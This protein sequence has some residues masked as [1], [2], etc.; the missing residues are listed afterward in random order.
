MENSGEY[1]NRMVGGFIVICIAMIAISGAFIAQNY[2]NLTLLGAVFIGIMLFL[3][4][5]LLHGQRLVRREI[6]DLKYHLGGPSDIEDGLLRRIDDLSRQIA[7]SDI[8]KLE[9]SIKSISKDC[10]ANNSSIQQIAEELLTVS[11]RLEDV[12]S[13][14]HALEAQNDP[15]QENKIIP[16]RKPRP[17]VAMAKST[18]DQPLI[19]RPM[20][21]GDIGVEASEVPQIG[22]TDL[23]EHARSRTLI[24]RLHNAVEN[25][26]LELHLQPIVKL[27]DREP[28]FYEST[29]RMKDDDGDYVKQQ[30]LL[31]F[32]NSEQLAVAFDSQLLH[33]AIRVLR[34]LNELQKR[35]GLFCPVSIATL[36]NALA[37]EEVHTLLR[38]NVALAGSLVLEIDQSVLDELD[39]EG[40]NRLSQLVELGYSLLLNNVNR[41]DLDGSLMHSAGFRNLKVSVNALL[42]ISDDGNI[43]EYVTDFSEEMENCGLTVIVCD[44]EHET[45]VMHL[46]D[47]DLP[48]GQGSLFSP[49]RPVKPELLKSPERD[50]TNSGFNIA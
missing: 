50:G 17:Q 18:A 19:S 26:E 36:N 29:L 1:R 49:S 38:A 16:L 27:L 41:F 9:H 39:A 46:I 2:L 43:D 42:E 3:L 32:V 21:D 25:E 6:N 4:L 44:I 30:R 48:L 14:S 13:N 47:F 23:A 8:S 28:E 33:A 35:T 5:Y 12:V 40:R 34:T 24:E 22:A 20:V 7:S 31:R 45:Q 10:A 37:F 15:P 11:E